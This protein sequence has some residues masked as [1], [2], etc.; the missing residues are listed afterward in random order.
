[1]RWILSTTSLLLGACVVAGSGDTGGSTGGS[2]DGGST[3]GSSS[4]DASSDGDSGQAPD[5]GG[6]GGTFD[7]TCPADDVAYVRIADTMFPQPGPLGDG[8][9]RIESIL[10]QGDRVFYTSAD[11]DGRH[12]RRV[13]FDGQGDEEFF[14]SDEFEPVSQLVAGNG[15]TAWWDGLLEPGRVV[16]LPNDLSA[17][18]VLFT[19][20][21]MGPLA[22]IEQYFDGAGNHFIL[23]N[24]HHE[25][26]PWRTQL[27][28]RN[29]TDGSIDVLYS[30]DQPVLG[31]AATL[32]YAYLGG[33]FYIVGEPSPGDDTFGILPVG[34]H[35]P[36]IDPAAPPAITPAS[37]MVCH[38]LVAFGAATMWC[39]GH[40]DEL[41]AIDGLF[42]M[43]PSGDALTATPVIRVDDQPDEPGRGIFVGSWAT[44]GPTLYFTSQDSVDGNAGIAS[45]IYRVIDIGGGD[46]IVDTV[47]CNLPEITD[48]TM[49]DGEVFFATFENDPDELDKHGLFRLE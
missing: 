5:V 10:V 34:D 28:R 42:A 45:S 19:D 3:G 20:V 11:F 44:D 21:L 18:E 22:D 17:P 9:A 46:F 29:V 8:W 4:A 36:A 7:F 26:E 49:T 14:R 39:L 6:G 13:A 47:A 48:M 24:V 23:A 2:S 43:K 16:A 30:R 12:I 40:E 31:G 37:T 35:D 1:M 27:L 15:A 41:G 25:G 33:T 38:D 32:T